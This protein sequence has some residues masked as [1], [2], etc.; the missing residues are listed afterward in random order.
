MSDLRLKW[1]SERRLDANTCRIA[2]WAP[3]RRHPLVEQP[4]QSGRI[5]TLGD[6]DGVASDGAQVRQTRTGPAGYRQ[7]GPNRGGEKFGPIEVEEALRSHPAVT[8][9][10]VAGIAD[11]EMG[12]RVGAAVMVRGPVTLDELR[13]HCAT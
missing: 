7:T 4:G 10:A 12:H 6:R 13:S 11:E 5:Q 3:R 9:V 8:D 2:A 1:R